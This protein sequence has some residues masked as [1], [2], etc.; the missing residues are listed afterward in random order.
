MGAG[1]MGHLV[2]YRDLA[3]SPI[4]LRLSNRAKSS[5]NYNHRRQILVGGC[6]C[7]CGV[8]GGVSRVHKTI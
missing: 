1:L 3:Y 7:S 6:G 2:S 8:Y 5:G 4:L